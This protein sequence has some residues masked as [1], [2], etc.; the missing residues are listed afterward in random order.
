[1]RSPTFN[2]I[3][4]KPRA[5]LQAVVDLPTP[6]LPE[7]T[8]MTCC[9]PG[10]PAV[11]VVAVASGW[12]WVTDKQVSW[13]ARRLS[14]LRS[15]RIILLGFSRSQVVIGRHHRGALWRGMRIETLIDHGL[16]AAIR[17]HLDDIQPSRVRALEH[18]VLL[19]QL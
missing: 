9:T 12:G 11:F 6:P 16:D 17:T 13:C 15:R 4:A 18:P 10:I 8:A 2:P 14:L 5:R 1:S 7:A 3:A 19:L